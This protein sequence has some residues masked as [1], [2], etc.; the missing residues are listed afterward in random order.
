[1]RAWLEVD[2]NAI[3]HNY[4]LVKQKVGRDVGVIG[5]VKSD[6]Y[7]HGLE[8]VVK[9]LDGQDIDIFAVIDLN[10]AIRVRAVSQRPVLILGYLDAKETIEAIERGFI[11]S[12]YDREAIAVIQR[13]AERLGKT[14]RVHVKIETGLNRLGMSI[15]EAIDFLSGQRMFPN[16]K[17]EAIYSHLTDASDRQEDLKQLRKIQ[18]FLTDM[19]DIIDL[20]P[21][22]L[23][24]SYSLANFSEGYFDAV[25][26]GLALYGVDEVLPGLIPSLQCKSLIAQVK[27]LK[28]G[29]GTSYEHLFIAP[30]DMTIAIISIGYG[31]GL[32]QMLTG[33]AQALIKGKKVPIIGKICM[34]LCVIDTK[35]LP[36]K[37][38]D[39]AVLIGSQKDDRGEIETLTV[40]ELARI[41]LMR[42]HEIITRL[43]CALPRIYQGG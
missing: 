27:P 23:A 24:S 13:T 32:S 20:L 35:G 6:A 41:S 4:Q 1:M 39:E 28:K 34:N 17:V 42:H 38:G 43:G 9:V 37:R 33:K 15:E 22:H 25:R 16:I 12:L 18:D 36:V 5:V 2:L 29:E 30:E 26:V 14:A 8:E 19:R 11:L 3:R 21:I 40:S 10:E 7:G 31:E